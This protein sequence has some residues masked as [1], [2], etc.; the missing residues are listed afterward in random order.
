M[1]FTPPDSPRRR[2]RGREEA[3]RRQRA[4]LARDLGDEHGQAWAHQTPRPKRSKFTLIVGAIFIAFVV[5]GALPLVLRS[6]DGQLVQPNCTT[7]AVATGP[8]KIKPGTNFAWQAAGPQQGPYVLALDAGIGD[9]S[10]RRPDHA[11]QRPGAVRTA[12]ADRLPLPADARGGPRQ[13]WHARSR[14]VPT[15]RHHVDPGSRVLTRSVLAGHGPDD[16]LASMQ[17]GCEGCPSPVPV[18][19]RSCPHARERRGCS[20]SPSVRRRFPA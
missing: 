11:G 18:K 7:P 1:A 13:Q 12:D 4:R 2:D 14:A 9:R 6:G 20:A 17:G 8:A 10:G 5:L 15:H 19:E 3:A 16:G